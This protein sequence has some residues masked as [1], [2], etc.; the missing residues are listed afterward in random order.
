MPIVQ[1]LRLMPQHVW[2]LAPGGGYWDSYIV[3]T[4]ILHM[5]GGSAIFHMYFCKSYELF[6]L[7]LKDFQS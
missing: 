6:Q 4:G 3:S 7:Y 2:L 5:G 1:I